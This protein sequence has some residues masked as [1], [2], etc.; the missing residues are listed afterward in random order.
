MDPYGSPHIVP[1][2]SLHNPFP[3]SLLRT[4]QQ[5]EAKTRNPQPSA[6]T[7]NPVA[8]PGPLNPKP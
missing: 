5:H 4:R 2:T 3:H 8:L 1:N 7:L 6:F